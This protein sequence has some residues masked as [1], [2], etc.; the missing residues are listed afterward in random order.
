MASARAS[1][2][3]AV[4]CGAHFVHDGFTDLIYLLLPVWQGEFGLTLAAAGLLKTLF[5]GGMAG[6]QV[7]A[8][9]LAERVGERRLLALGTLVTAAAYFFAGWSA[10]FAVLALCLLLGGAGTSVQHPLSSSLVSRAFE[11]RHL[12]TALGTYNFAGDVGKVVVPFTAAALI[13][14]WQWRSAVIVLAVGGALAALAILALLPREQSVAVAAEAKPAKSVESSRGFI[15][16][17]VIGMIDATTRTGFLTFLPFLFVAKG[18][19]VALIGTALS[20]VFAGGAAGKFA[21]GATARR[22]GVLRT[23]ILTEA[24]TAAGILLLL[25]LGLGYGFWLLPLIGVA[26]NGTSSVLYG[27]VAELAAPERRA[28]A[29]GVFY[30]VTLGAGALAPLV[31]GAF[32][33]R[34]G[35]PTILA[36]IALIVLLVVPLTLPLRR[37]LAL[38]AQA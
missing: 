35:V 5:S 30:S 19:S 18:A 22:V 31:Y 6:L 17:C 13:A 8:G 24:A 1:R 3:L 14:L 34:L 36:V 4:C 27:T 33:D 7:P 28:R 29:F 9:L 15:A 10:G 2:I 11:G 20:L 38:L 16:L 37:P 25:P 21:C 23:V 32:S 12:R 26:L